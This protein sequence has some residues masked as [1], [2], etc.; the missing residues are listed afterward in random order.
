MIRAILFDL[1][2]TLMYS[3]APWPPFKARATRA[4]SDTLCAAG[5][6]ID[7]DTFDGDFQ[8][9]LDKYYAE[10][11]RSLA[12][13]TVMTILR[14]LLIEQG[15][16]EPPEQQ[17]RVALDKFYAI[18]QENWK[19]EDDAD[20]T[21]KTLQTAG[22]R[23]GLI[24]NAGDER[25]VTQLVAKFGIGSYFDFIVT[26]AACGYRKPHPYIFSV[27]LSRWGCLPDEIVMV[28]D[29]LDA[30]IGGAKPLGIYTVLVKRRARKLLADALTPN[31]S[32]ESLAELPALIG[33]LNGKK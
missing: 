30:D 17:L 2:D 11:D 13:P 22:F 16:L 9:Q 1:G 6:S 31:A 21:L 25:D 7:C 12:E 4:L 27:A 32:V 28:G 8:Q 23:L 20:A 15:E 10:R 19:L 18:T 24:S 29:R 33:R 26:S 3:P 5:L 14:D